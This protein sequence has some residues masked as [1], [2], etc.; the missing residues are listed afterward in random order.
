MKKFS[1]DMERSQDTLLNEKGTQLYTNYTT[2]YE[3]EEGTGQ[4]S[5][6]RVPCIC[7]KTY[8]KGYQKN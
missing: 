2:L 8:L 6:F 5:L 4:D 7:I 1:H 3:G